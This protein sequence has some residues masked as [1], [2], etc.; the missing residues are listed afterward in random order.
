[1][2]HTKTFFT[3]SLYD[4]NRLPMTLVNK[5]LQCILCSSKFIH[6]VLYLPFNRFLGRYSTKKLHKADIHKQRVYGDIVRERYGNV[7][8]VTCY[9]PE[10]MSVIMEHEGS[11]PARSDF[12]TLK[13][14]REK[15]KEW[16]QP[17]GILIM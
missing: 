12:S 16:Y 11:Y 14:Y 13:A 17:P 6:S 10:A 5:T 9:D 3:N 15:R 8:F 1:M 7:E 2:I 4:V